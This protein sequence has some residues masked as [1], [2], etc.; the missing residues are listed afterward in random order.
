MTGIQD[1]DKMGYLAYYSGKRVVVAG[2]GGF[3]GSHVV[4]R[5]KHT[6]AEILIPRTREGVDFTK[7]DRC[8]EYL[9]GAK[10]HILINCA[11]HQGGIKYQRAREG[12]IYWD[13]LLIATFLMEAA[14]RAGVEKFI[15]V[16]ASCSYPGYSDRE[17]LAEE[18]YWNGPL[19]ESVLNYGFTKKAQ[20]V[21][22]WCYKQEYSFNSIHLVVT[23]LYG[24]REHFHPDRSH[25]LAALLK[26]FYDAKRD[27]QPEVEIWGTGTPVR[28]WLYVKDAAEGILLAGARYNDV[29]PLNIG[30]GKGCSITELA[31]IMMQ[32]LEYPCSLRYLTEMPDGARRKVLSVKRMEEEL[33]W[34]PRTPIEQG[35]KDTA[36]WLDRNYEYATAY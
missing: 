15:A 36:E 3:L 17:E 10:P 9:E 31:H 5:L 35:I 33:G 34:L 19:H 24:P 28:E 26:K 30:T 32:V 20:V 18:D 27:K 11:A 2:G 1:H 12:T 7:F 4:D 23:G 14:R 16:N 13:N 29:A 8:R 6:D 22:G 25:A 21:Q